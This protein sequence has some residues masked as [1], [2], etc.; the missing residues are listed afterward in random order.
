[1]TTLT[2][3]ELRD[4]GFSEGSP[5]NFSGFALDLEVTR[6]GWP[7]RIQTTIGNGQPL[8]LTAQK[9][10]PSTG[11]LECAIYNQAYGCTSITI[12]ND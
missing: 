7:A 11:D 10:N 1:M 4:S 3:S 2:Y 8:L 9:F 5:N 12:F 6:K